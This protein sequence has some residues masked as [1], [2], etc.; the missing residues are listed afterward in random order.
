MISARADAA[1]ISRYGF[2][3]VYFST[4]SAAA[5]TTGV[6]KFQLVV[7]SLAKNFKTTVSVV[8]PDSGRI[9]TATY[10][11]WHDVADWRFIVYEWVMSVV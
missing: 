11:S 7:Q 4:S 9:V 6:S 5:G 8:I 1:P 10:L 2:A 3:N